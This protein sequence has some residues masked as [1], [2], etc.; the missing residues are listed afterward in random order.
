M[1]P[2]TGPQPLRLVGAIIAKGKTMKIRRFS[3]ILAVI[4]LEAGL[5]IG[6]SSVAN[7]LAPL[8]GTVTCNPLAGSGHFSH[9]I[10]ANGTASSMHIAYSGALSG[11]VGTFGSYSVTG[12]SVTAS[13]SFTGTDVNKCSNFEGPYPSGLSAD[14]IDTIHVT[15]HWTSSPA[16]TWAP[17]HVTYTGQFESLL[18]PNLNQVSP[19]PPFTGLDLFVVPPNNG[20]VTTTT[21]TGS[22][23][24]TGAATNMMINVPS[25]SQTTGCPIGPDFTFNSVAM[26]FQ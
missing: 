18:Y 22:Y 14:S 19:G 23:A 20:G 15:V 10:K 2:S 26:A 17:S 7:A 11:C 24:G 12:G 3:A 25:S 4:V 21:V 5:V 6:L 13:G 1:H 8:A 16:H 9:K